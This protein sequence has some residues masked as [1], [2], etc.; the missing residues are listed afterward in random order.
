MKIDRNKYLNPFLKDECVFECPVCNKGVLEFSKD[1]SAYQS[2]ATEASKK[3]YEQ[4]QEEPV[5]DKSFVGI[6]KCSN[7]KCNEVATVIGH[8]SFDGPYYP[9][10]CE[11]GTTCEP[12][13]EEVEEFKELH[14]ISYIDPPIFITHFPN[15]TPNEVREFLVSSFKLFWLDPPSAGNKIRMALEK[16]MDERKIENGRLHRRIENFGVIENAKYKELSEMLMGVK[17]LGNIGSHNDK[18]EKKDLLDAYDV[19]SYV[20]DEIFARENRR[21]DAKNISDRFANDF[22]PKNHD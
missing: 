7:K 20:L 14:H 11:P 17:W 12:M 16:L 19:M 1:K 5:L 8:I 18:L 22:K 21:I 10:Y 15:Q 13:C 6:L 2:V 3:F 4:I 9:H